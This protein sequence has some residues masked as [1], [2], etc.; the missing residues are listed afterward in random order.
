MTL[1]I[2]TVFVTIA[3]LVVLY[4]VATWWLLWSLVGYFLTN[5]VGL[6]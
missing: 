2:R 4:V 3:T 1:L 6:F 5:V